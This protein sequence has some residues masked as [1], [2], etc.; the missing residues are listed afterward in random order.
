M[1]AGL[2]W[3]WTEKA[4][5]TN[6]PFPVVSWDTVTGHKLTVE[7]GPLPFPKLW[8]PLCVGEVGWCHCP[9]GKH[10][11]KTWSCARQL[12]SISDMSH[13]FTSSTCLLLPL[14]SLS[15]AVYFPFFFLPSIPVSSWNDSAT[16]RTCLFFSLF[17]CVA[18]YHRCL[19]WIRIGSVSRNWQ[20]FSS[21]YVT[22]GEMA[23]C[24][25][26]YCRLFAL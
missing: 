25:A 18:F 2:K 7:N 21:S 11:I 8:L 20:A 6:R 19:L 16:R 9:W 10:F 4:I 23:V 13:C 1:D 15:L 22:S 12:S 3:S 14:L 24:R 26:E 5:L 17:S